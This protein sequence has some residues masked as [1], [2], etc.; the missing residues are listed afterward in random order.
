MPSAQE[1]PKTPDGALKRLLAGNDRLLANQALHPQTLDGI[2]QH[3]TGQ[4]PY[5]QVFGCADSRVPVEAVF[6]EDFG[7]VFVTRTAGNVLADP[8]IGTIEYGVVALG[9]PLIMVL[10]HQSCGAVKAA[11]EAMKDRSKLPS[12]A[13]GALVS[14]LV[15][16]AREAQARGG[17][18]YAAALE[19]HIRK[20]VKTL[21]DNKAFAEPIA[22][23]KL[24]VVGASYDL[25]TAKVTMYE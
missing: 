24:R 1:L 15:P 9:T 7:D 18:I 11:V 13:L 4:A 16:A 17:D 22:Q 23:G 12:G 20:V 14:A 3:A 6:D 5:A 25:A 19:V 21:Q 8:T 2:R 10:G